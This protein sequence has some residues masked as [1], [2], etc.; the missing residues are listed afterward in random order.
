MFIVNISPRTAG[1]TTN[2]GWLSKALYE[3]GHRVKGFDAD[4]SQQWIQWHED[5]KAVEEKAEGEGKGVGFPFEIV[6]AATP[7]FHHQHSVPDNV[8]GVVDCGHSE[9]HPEITDSLL[10]VAD[11][12]LVHMSPTSSDFQRLTE[13]MEG[14]PLKDMITRSAPLR[15][16]TVAP[17]AWVLL[18][19]VVHNAGSTRA[20]RN[21]LKDLGWNVLTTTI[22]R[23]EEFA[24]STLGPVY[25]ADDTNFGALVTELERKGLIK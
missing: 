7:R 10:R 5:A 22:P 11:L 18:N 1:K 9:N 13:P 4:H 14:T 15:E 19:R 25:D 12:A 24:N 2:S 16:T 17:P 3:R 6:S 23:N 8:I 21:K 20:Y